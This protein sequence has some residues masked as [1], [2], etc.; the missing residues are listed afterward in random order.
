MKSKRPA[1]GGRGEIAAPLFV[2]ATGVLHPTPVLMVMPD[3]SG[4][5][6][7]PQEFA[8]K[9]GMVEAFPNVPKESAGFGG[10]TKI[11]DSEDLLKLLNTDPKEHVDARDVSYRAVDGFPLSTTTIGTRAT[12]SA[13]AVAVR[14][15][16]RVGARSR[17]TTRP[18]IRARSTGC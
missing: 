3:D 13:G 6:K 4:A 10:A 18:R 2:A 7:I 1:S 16:D 12:G 8:G 15:E 14:T 11:I 9:L 5:G 17:A